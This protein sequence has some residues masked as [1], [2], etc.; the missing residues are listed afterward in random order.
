MKKSDVIDGLNE[1]ISIF[2]SAVADIND[3]WD[4][5]IEVE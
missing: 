5:T 2:K 3:D 4:G 1:R